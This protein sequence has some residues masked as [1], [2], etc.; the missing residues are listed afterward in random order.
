MVHADGRDAD[1]GGG[2]RRRCRGAVV[3]GA[4][5]EGVAA[6]DVVAGSSGTLGAVLGMLPAAGPAE[7]GRPAEAGGWGACR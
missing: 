7:T 1:G 6:A 3:A 2:G 4:V 5:V